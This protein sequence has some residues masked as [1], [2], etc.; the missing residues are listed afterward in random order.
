[1]HWY[2]LWYWSVEEDD[3][4]DRQEN[5]DGLGQFLIVLFKVNSR[6]QLL[7]DPAADDILDL[8]QHVLDQ[9]L[10]FSQS[11]ADSLA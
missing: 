3:E 10:W 2:Y 8:A 5:I 1:M 9:V 7:T 11:F 6:A 4:P